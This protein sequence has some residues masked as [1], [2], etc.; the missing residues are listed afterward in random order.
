MLLKSILEMSD[1]ERPASGG[2]VGFGNFTRFD[3]IATG[4]V[5]SSSA[6]YEECIEEFGD[7]TDPLEGSSKIE[8]TADVGVLGPAEYCRI[9]RIEPK[10]HFSL[11]ALDSKPKLGDGFKVIELLW[12]VTGRSWLVGGPILFDCYPS[13]LRRDSCPE[14][15]CVTT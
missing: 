13:R 4:E 1:C 8:S 11:S 9:C 5:S 15:H 2:R 7:S 3:W 12:S 10:S 14:S 6:M